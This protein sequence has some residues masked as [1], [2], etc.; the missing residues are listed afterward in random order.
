MSLE[1]TC[2]LIQF[3]PEQKGQGKNGEWVKQDF[4]VETL[5]EYPKKIAMGAWGDLVKKINDYAPDSILKVSFRL[6]SREFNGR[7]YTD[8]RPWKIESQNGQSA[9]A[10]NGNAATQNNY[11]NSGAAVTADPMAGVQ[12]G[13]DDLPF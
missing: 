2:K 10:S 7:W 12:D 4:I 3:L 13:N 11:S 8:V 9:P 5:G 6:E 1:L